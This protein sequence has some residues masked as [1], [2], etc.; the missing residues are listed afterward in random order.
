MKD[1]REWHAQLYS[2]EQTICAV[3]ERFLPLYVGVLIGRIDSLY[4]KKW[5]PDILT[6]EE[7]IAFDRDILHYVHSSSSYKRRNFQQAKERVK[8]I[9]LPALEKYITEKTN[10]KEKIIIEE[11]QFLQLLKEAVEQV[12]RKYGRIVE[13][14]LESQNPPEKH[15]E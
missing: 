11:A 5:S 13:K 6:Q 2:F 10:K 15:E 4:D 3:I 12:D 14:L 9:L 8:E 1:S 7:V